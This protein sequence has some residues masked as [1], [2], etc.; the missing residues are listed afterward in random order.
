MIT[1][2]L[3]DLLVKVVQIDKV[4]ID[5]NHRLQQPIDVVPV[6]YEIEPRLV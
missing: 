3:V 5:V 2:N 4:T 1:Y 6:V